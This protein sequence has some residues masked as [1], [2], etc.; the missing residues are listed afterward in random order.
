MNIAGFVEVKLRRSANLVGGVDSRRAK[1][2]F[3]G[4]PGFLECVWWVLELRQS[5]IGW[6]SLV[7]SWSSSAE[8]GAAH[9]VQQPLNPS[10]ALA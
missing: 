9:S 2:H 4:K 7:L 3:P 5:V 8:H 1:P 10:S 6:A